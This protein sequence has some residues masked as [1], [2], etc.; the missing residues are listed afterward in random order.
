M[1]NNIQSAVR[2]FNNDAELAKIYEANSY[3]ADWVK[4]TVAV[5]AQTVKYRQ[6]SFGSTVLGDFNRETGYTRKDI[7]VTWK[8]KTMTQDKGDSLVLDRMDGEEAQGLNIVESGKN[9]QRKNL[10]PC[11]NRQNLSASVR[12]KLQKKTC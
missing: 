6:E 7:N 2:Y 5:G 3:T 11:I 1:A 8:E 12:I 10:N 4:P 9:Y